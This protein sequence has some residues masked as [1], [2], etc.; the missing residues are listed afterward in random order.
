MNRAAF[1]SLLCSIFTLHESCC[2]PSGPPAPPP[3]VVRVLPCWKDYITCVHGCCH[4]IAHPWPK[5]ATTLLSIGPDGH[6]PFML[7]AIRVQQIRL[8]LTD[9]NE[10]DRSSC[11]Q[12]KDRKTQWKNILNSIKH[13]AKLLQPGTIVPCGTLQALLKQLEGTCRTS[14]QVNPIHQHTPKTIGCL[15]E[16]N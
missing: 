3:G 1:G 5:H 4:A 12:T 7:Y 9:M 6:D 16:A 2:W 14:T 13:M 8:F 15:N 11:G 10:A